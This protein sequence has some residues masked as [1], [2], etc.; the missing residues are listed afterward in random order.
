MRKICHKHPSGEADI[1]STWLNY[2]PT[3]M[4]LVDSSSCLLKPVTG[5]NLT[6]ILSSPDSHISQSHSQNLLNFILIQDGC[7]ALADPSSC[8]VAACAER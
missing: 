7:S 3:F 4:E 2:L 1:F 6:S 8:I 5:H